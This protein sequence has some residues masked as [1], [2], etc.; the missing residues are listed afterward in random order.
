VGFPELQQCRTAELGWVNED[1]VSR[2]AFPPAQDTKVFVCELTN[3][4]KYV[5][6]PR[7][8]PEVSSGSILS[9]LGYTNEMVVKF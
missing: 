7:T 1:K 3:V 5:C 2:H 8:T 9:N 6:G 4:Y